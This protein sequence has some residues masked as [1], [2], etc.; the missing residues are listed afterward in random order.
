MCKND[1][2]LKYPYFTFENKYTDNI[3]SQT[4]LQ[5]DKHNDRK[6]FSYYKNGLL[7]SIE[8]KGCIETYNYEFFD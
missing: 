1:Y 7:K 3:L 4:I 6:V 2:G 8:H 5:P